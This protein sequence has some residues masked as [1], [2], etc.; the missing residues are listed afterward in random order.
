M[1]KTPPG[2]MVIV[3]AP[4]GRVIAHAADFHR[5]RPG[6]YK[7]R[8][9]QVYR[10]KRAAARATVDAYCSP[11]IL[12]ALGEYE[13]DLIVHKLRDKGHTMTEIDIGGHD[14]DEDC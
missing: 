9:A 11:V 12:E 10:A 14:D 2:V 3:T 13:I 6:G 8:E 4:D 7:L 5:D 1:P